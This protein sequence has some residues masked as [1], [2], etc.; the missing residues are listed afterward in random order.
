MA[1]TETGWC[2][3]NS[4]SKTHPIGEKSANKLGLHDMVGNVMEWVQDWYAPEYYAESPATDPQGANTSSYKVYRGGA[5]LSDAKQCR[6]AYRGFDL[7]NN[8]HDSVGFRL[9]RTKR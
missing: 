7:P 8:T 5:W 6:P 4:A 2:E 3:S 9:V 1:A